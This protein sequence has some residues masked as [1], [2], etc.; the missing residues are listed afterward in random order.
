MMASQSPQDDHHRKISIL[1]V[2]SHE[3]QEK[4]EHH[5]MLR[6]AR[7]HASV[8]ASSAASRG[9][10]SA[11]TNSTTT[12][13]TTNSTTTNSTTTNSQRT[14]TN[15][16]LTIS[17]AK[18]ARGRYMAI[19]DTHV[20]SFY[21]STI[22]RSEFWNTL[23]RLDRVMTLDDGRG[24]EH[25]DCL[26]A[27]VFDN[28]DFLSDDNED[29]EDNQNWILSLLARALSQDNEQS[30]S[31]SCSSSATTTIVGAVTIDGNYLPPGRGRRR[32]GSSYSSNTKNHTNNH[33]Q[34]HAYIANLAV[35]ETHRRRGV[36]ERLMLEAEA[37]ARE[38]G[39]RWAVL[40]V[41]ERNVAGRR[42]Y[43]KLGYRTVATQ[44]RW[45][46]WMEGRGDGERLVLMV[47]L[48]V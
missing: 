15:S 9:S 7:A 30:C 46:G 1:A 26:V 31:S 33:R 18:E 8:S 24:R 14:T 6:I 29:N 19:A 20:R 43:G 28:E 37:R 41:D 2:R 23:L 12:N 32:Y 25:V 4:R 48:V 35:R 34:R 47:K 44:S 36:A 17:S 13:S 27:C 11:A 3:K 40:H 22:S 45:Q 42:L 5:A 38:F 39:C 10:R 16:Q 21:G